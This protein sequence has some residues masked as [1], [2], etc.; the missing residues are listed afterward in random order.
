M[1]AAHSKLTDFQGFLLYTERSAF[2]C[3]SALHASLTAA[4]Q[5]SRFHPPFTKRTNNVFRNPG[6][7][8]WLPSGP[9]GSEQGSRKPGRGSLLGEA[10]LTGMATLGNASKLLLSEGRRGLYSTNCL[11][12]P[13]LSSLL[14][15]WHHIKP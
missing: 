12:G 8:G 1:I 13:S 11:H 6:R 15:S 5:M 9:R 14:S 2:P 3:P 7:T 4:L 10:F